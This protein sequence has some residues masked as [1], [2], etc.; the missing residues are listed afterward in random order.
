MAVDASWVMASQAPVCTVTVS[1]VLEPVA[2]TGTVGTDTTVSGRENLTAQAAAGT[3]TFH[4]GP[5]GGVR[6]GQ[7]RMR[8]DY[9]GTCT[10]VLRDTVTY[11]HM[12]DCTQNPPAG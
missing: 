3:C 10:V 8:T 2:L 1:W 5:R 12:N 11:V 4:W 9:L 6:Q 7:W